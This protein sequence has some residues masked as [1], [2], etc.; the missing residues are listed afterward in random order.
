MWI[1][2]KETGAKFDIE[3]PELIERLKKDS[4]YEI[5]EEKKESKKK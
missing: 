5:T 4:D 2:N 3:D 1:L